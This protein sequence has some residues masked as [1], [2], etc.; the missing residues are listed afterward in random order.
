VVFLGGGV[1]GGLGGVGW[2]GVVFCF[3]FGVWGGGGLGLGVLGWFWVGSVVGRV[4]FRPI[5]NVIWELRGL[6]RATA[7][8]G[9]EQTYNNLTGSN[10]KKMQLLETNSVPDH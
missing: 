10:Q 4:R 6:V 1:C 3:G 2:V 7:V 9:G 8:N 5:K